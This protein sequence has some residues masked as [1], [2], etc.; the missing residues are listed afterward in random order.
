M[1]KMP[2]ASQKT[3][4]ITIPAEE[5]VSQGASTAPSSDLWLK[6]ADPTVILSEKTAKKTGLVCFK[7]SQGCL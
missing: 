5:G 4:I 2:F 3:E 6:V 7:Y 1:N